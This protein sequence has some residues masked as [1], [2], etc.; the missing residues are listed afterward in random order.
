[1]ACSKKI[2]K[3]K[4]RHQITEKN[5][6]YEHEKSRLFTWLDGDCCQ[7]YPK[8]QPLPEKPVELVITKL[9]PPVNRNALV[10]RTRLLESLRQSGARR[11]TLVSAPAGFGKSTLLAQWQDI[12]I[13]GGMDCCWLSVDCEDRDVTRFLRYIIGALQTIDPEFGRRAR[14][15]LENQTK[16]DVVGVVARIFNEVAERG[17]AVA[18]FIDDYYLADCVE[19]NDAMQTL[20]SRAPRNFHFILASRAIPDL[21]LATLRVHDD[22]ME[23]DAAELRFDIEEASE[24]MLKSR[25]LELTPEQ[26]TI[27]QDRTEGWIAGL[28]L[29]SLSLKSRQ[30]RDEFF[31]AFSGKLRDITDYL[32]D[33]VWSKLSGDI[34]RFLLRTS[35]LGRLNADLC[36]LLDNRDDS[37]S[38]LDELEAQNLFLLPLDEERIWYRYHHLF[39]DFLRLQLAR[40]YP[41]EIKKLQ[42]L[43]SQWFARNGYANEA[44]N[45]ALEAENFE[46]AAELVQEH[47]FQMI[48][49]GQMAKVNSWIDKIP[50]EVAARYPRLPMYQ[51]WALFHMRRPR[52][53]KEALM[54]TDI[55]ITQLEK[56][57]F[58]GGSAADFALIKSLREEEKVLKAGVAI[59]ADDV[60]Q[61]KVLAA[62]VLSGEPGKLT[63]WLIAV[64]GNIYGYSCQSRSEFAEAK[65]ILTRARVLHE[66]VGAFFGIVYSDCFMGMM[67]LAQGHLHRAAA[68]FQQA[69]DVALKGGMPQRSAGTGI[70]RILRSAV[71]YEWGRLDEARR[72]IDGN[73]DMVEECSHIEGEVTG[74]ITLARLHALEGDWPRA[75]N[76]LGRARQIC[77]NIGAGRQLVQVLDELVR[78]SLH[79]GH[80]D[81]AF[82][83]AEDM[84]LSLDCEPE[85][86]IEIWDRITYVRDLIRVRLLVS[87]GA[88]DKAL[89]DLA[90]LKCQARH[91]RHGRREIQ[92]MMLESL[93]L[94]NKGAL[95][96]AVVRF[97]EATELARPDGYIRSICD[98][99]EGVG[100]L[101]NALQVHLQTAPSDK[102]VG[103]SISVRRYLDQLSVSI[104]GP[105]LDQKQDPSIPANQISR[106]SVMP[107][108]FS[109]REI[110]VLKLLAEG[111][112]NRVIA[113]ELQIAENTVKWHVKN[114]FEKLGV[115]NRTTA[116][117]RCQSLGLLS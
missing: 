82:D 68:L 61:G 1:V 85:S 112:A 47:A 98:A 106:S 101:I 23:L 4:G 74:H 20:L 83:I 67:E 114:I 12:L 2:V 78:L 116:V 9:F 64:M 25:G 36:N 90:H 104:N 97:A 55:A 62:A 48:C 75:E 73:L 8:G 11:L 110:E 41:A 60:D 17:R 14:E 35:V 57:A 34:Q 105:S 26:I 15:L 27:L 95:S 108:P 96:D 50:G 33:D 76:I 103:H 38:R 58:A 84:R 65:E 3:K 102:T 53:A 107:E 21:R 32:T 113:T 100:R 66:Q 77:E 109:S 24:F 54:R 86:R 94:L 59:A 71:L 31:A 70:A 28:Q 49:M 79:F 63:N 40:R 69:E 93:V 5:Y 29:A 111:Q 91:F 46:G 19:V 10:G 18:I 56:A 72:L 13:A 88:W 42:N 45:Y 87:E 6:G 80:V 81:T 30:N 99:G 92:A 51:C 43:A 39:S 16:V 7:D 44:V 115:T 22:I 89:L 52:E 37:Q 117:L